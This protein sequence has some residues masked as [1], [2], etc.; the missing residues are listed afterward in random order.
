[1]KKEIV[2]IMSILLLP[3]VSMANE[4]QDS[5][6][7]N[8]AIV[9]K[10][11]AKG[12]V[13]KEDARDFYKFYLTQGLEIRLEVI[14]TDDV[15]LYLYNPEKKGVAY[16]CNEY[17]EYISYRIDMNGYWYAEIVGTR[18]D[19]D[20]TISLNILTPQNDMGYD[21][22]AGDKIY[23]AFAIFPNEPLD[24]TPGRGNTG[25]LSP[26]GDKED[27]YIF[28]ACT[29]QN[30]DIKL[31]PTADMDMEL[32]N[33]N[34]EVIAYSSNSGISSEEIIYKAE[35]TGNYY[36]RILSKDG[37]EGY[38]TLNVDL[39][40]QND[41]G[42]GIDAGNRLSNAL[43]VAPGSYF[44]FMDYSDTVDC[45]SFNVA[46]GETINIKLTSPLQS[47]Y[48][49]WLYNPAGKLV[50][51]A[52]YYGDDE[53]SYSAD[54]GGEWKIKIDMFPG[55]D[56]KWDEY[57][58]AYYKYGSG[59]YEFE[60]SFGGEAEK[61]PTIEQPEIIPI[62][63]T[64]VVKNDANSNKDEYSYIAAV[65]ASNYL[66][67]GKRYVSPIVYE[68]D[69]T[70]TNWYGSVDDTTS[71]LLEDWNEYLSHF[72]KEAKV[73]YM[74]NEPIKAAAELA[75][76][77]WSKSNEAVIVIDGSM[78]KDEVKEV[79]SKEDTLNIRKS[80]VD[81]R[82]NDP[83]LKEFEGQIVY[84][85]F[86]GSKWGA[87]KYNLFEV[88]GQ[89]IV[90]TLIDPKYRE[91]ATDWWPYNE[92]RIDIFHPITLPG[93]W[94]A[95]V[96][97]KGN[98]RMHIEMYSCKRYYIPVF[99]SD[100][101]L[102]VTIETDEPSY[103]WVY[104]VDPLGNII[105]PDMPSWNGAK[106]KPIH[107]WNGNK[108]VG[109]E[110]D[111]SHLIVEPHTS[112][113]AEAHHPMKGIWTAIVVPR[114][115]MTGS[116]RYK[117]KAELREYNEK[118]I[119]YGLSAANG[120]VIASIKHIPLLYANE[121]GIPDETMDALNSLG[122]RK[123]IFIDLAGNEKVAN[124]ISSNFEMER[125]TTLKDIIAKIGSNENYI[126]IT[127]FSGD[128]YFAQASYIAAYHSSPVLRIG[129]M[130]YAYHWATVSHQWMFYAGDYYHGCRS[131]G[132]LAMAEKPIIDYIKEGEIPPIGLDA[133]L[134]WMSK[135]VDA[136]YSYVKSLGIDINGME[137]Y[138]V[139]ASKSDI[140]FTFHHPLIGNESAAG[141]FIGKTPGEMAAYVARSVLYPA[142]IFANPHKEYTTSS[143]I[144]YRD[145]RD[146]T[147]NDGKRYRAYTTR[148]NLIYFRA[149]GREYRGHCVWD[150]LLFEQNNGVSVY[151]YSGH[152][153]GGS[154][155]SGHPKG[156]GIGIDGWRGY[157]Y[158]YGRTPR[159]G[160]F[161]WYDP[162]PP[163]EYDIV[164]FKWCDMLWENLHSIWIHFSSCTT[165][166]HF[167]PNIYLDHGAVAYYGNCGAGIL[168]YNDLWDE[169]IEEAIMR[170][171]LP[172][173]EAISKDVWKFERDFTTLDPTSI[174]GTLSIN[175]LSMPVLYGDPALIIYSPA[176]WSEPTPID[177]N[178]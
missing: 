34:A 145:G 50:A 48:N 153:T 110:Y 23:K 68:G 54:I 16:S 120:A 38:Y 25:M 78:I 115:D 167:G 74:D 58:V 86:V 173:G 142:L 126:T 112:F 76:K 18:G 123:V 136:V 11:V 79:I 41:A 27:W 121:E 113:S 21:R 149:F 92:D 178:L 67:D 139:V 91:V 102:K 96:E 72:N 45:Y 160:G 108:T 140:R 89:D 118:R 98:W 90:I 146:W 94:A 52:T 6:D 165:A 132:H 100:A 73:Y 5:N 87:I 33:E 35:Y 147:G 69:N 55:Y 130:G 174:Y 53:L 97:R 101:S 3:L 31:L 43:H 36:L 176:H 84:P 144:N 143:F 39:K 158:W 125:I 80:V 77:A 137:N 83:R 82:G 138:C 170:Y 105:A 64:I 70:I 106:I 51:Q 30:I 62:S 99:N 156:K 1:M 161:T 59:G 151:Y 44:G 164:H 131:I 12:S 135:I 66:K 168:G 49:I 42:M 150:N 47:D 155:V 15:D 111:Y 40:G 154:G 128:G 159:S 133:D 29:G 32:L 56:S 116:I 166:W 13:G 127:S 119:A 7:F 4:I 171:G 75:R 22:D 81:I 60:I 8:D 37:I 93:M 10:D 71:Y 20:Y 141:Q 88:N 95:A 157:A 26:P 2:I 46:A 17:C 114:E 63:Q 122:V 61:L 103:L 117:I 152:G 14:A 85:F 163:A 162:E 124:A 28:S 24:N 57:P 134:R 148:E 172:V 175:M 129:E 177:S 109:D 169:F 65:P 104:L 9:L 19:A 107:K